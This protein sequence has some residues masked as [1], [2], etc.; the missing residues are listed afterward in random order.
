M[1]HCFHMESPSRVF[2][3]IPGLQHRAESFCACNDAASMS[4]SYIS[5]S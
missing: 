5:F 1:P 3:V 4:V 2:S